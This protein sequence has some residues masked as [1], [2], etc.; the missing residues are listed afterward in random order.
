[1]IS[2]GRPPFSE[3]LD[4]KFVIFPGKCVT[5]M[6]S[7]VDGEQTTAPNLIRDDKGNPPVIPLAQSRGSH[8]PF[9]IQDRLGL[10]SVPKTSHTTSKGV[11]LVW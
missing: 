10:F 3:G 11:A 9:P 7:G 2:P 6:D 1:M 8:E 4:V 5:P